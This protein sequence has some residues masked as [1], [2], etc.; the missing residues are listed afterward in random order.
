VDPESS[1][2]DVRCH[3]LVAGLT[4]WFPVS[5]ALL[6][7]ESGGYAAAIIY[8]CIFSPAI[9]CWFLILTDK[10]VRYIKAFGFC[11]FL[12]GFFG[13]VLFPMAAS[14]NGSDEDWTRGVCWAIFPTY[15]VI[16]IGTGVRITQGRG[17]ADYEGRMRLR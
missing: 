7:Y 9:I 15:F 6:L 14:L 10:D 17:I 5:F 16:G 3:A 4:Y 8:W 1:G 11:C 12:P 2:F 13:W